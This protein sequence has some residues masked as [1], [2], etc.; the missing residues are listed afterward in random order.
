M[1]Y[2]GIDLARKMTALCIM[3]ES[4]EVIRE[5]MVPTE[6]VDFRVF[7]KDERGLRCVVEASPLAEWVSRV[8]EGM[9]HTV[10]IID[11]RK[12]KAVIQTKKK[13]DLLDARNLAR[14]AR[15]GW[16]TA[17][18]RKSP[19]ARLLR[20]HLKA[21]DGLLRIVR[22]MNGQIRGLLRSHGIRLGAVSDKNFPAH[23]RELAARR[24][25]ALSPVLDPRAGPLDRRVGPGGRRGGDTEDDDRC[26]GKGVRGSGAAPNRSGGGPL[27][28]RD[29]RG[30]PGHP[31]P[32]PERQPGGRLP[33]AGSPGAPVRRDGIPWPGHQGRGQPSPDLADRGGGGAAH[34]HAEKLSPETVG[35]PAGPEKRNGQGHGGR[36]PEDGDAV[37]PSLEIGEDVS[38]GRFGVPRR[39]C[40]SAGMRGSLSDDPAHG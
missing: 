8:L 22:A 40:P 21:R 10:V 25:P 5:A 17:V 18:H 2:L 27:D 13:T 32:V 12:A 6:E 20:S 29:L 14:M 23:V 30:H 11:P 9:G 16:Y 39:C 38:T 37:V 7:L 33:G 3:N 35:A 19:E 1:L 24:M 4:G 36:R 34:A 31:R 15:T 28:R 26:M